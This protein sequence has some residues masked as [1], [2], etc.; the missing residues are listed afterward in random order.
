MNAPELYLDAIN[1]ADAVLRRALA[2]LSDNDLRSQPAGAQSNPIGWLV[3]HLARTRDTIVA[4]IS[5][6]PTIWESDGWSAAFGIHGDAPRFMPENVH[7]F[8]PKSAQTIIGYFEA[9]V[10]KTAAIIQQLAPH[11]LE[12]LVPST[13]AG[14]PPQTVG[15]RLS[16]ILNDNIQHI[17]QIAYLRGVIRGQGWL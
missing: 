7:M 2:D 4:G 10:H 13:V 16:V 5:G 12:R 3:W 15:A 11:D 14:R 8:D 9:V 1:R 17:G 6:Q